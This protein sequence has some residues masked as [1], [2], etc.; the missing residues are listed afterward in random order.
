MQISY[1]TF[2]RVHRRQE[3]GLTSDT[4][5]ARYRVLL[6]AEV[7]IRR[8]HSIDV[9]STADDF[10]RQPHVNIAGDVV[11]FSKSFDVRNERLAEA[12]KSDGRRI[13]LDIC[14]NHFDHPQYGPHFHHMIDLADALVASTPA[15][16]E[17][18]RAKTGRET[19]IIGDPVEG[20]RGTPRCEFDRTPVQ[21][22]WFGHPTNIESLF[23]LASRL[24]AMAELRALRLELVT[25]P[26]AQLQERISEWN[27]LHSDVVALSLTPWSVA[28]L[29]RSFENCDVVLLP[30]QSDERGS[31]KS[32]NR[33]IE[34]IWAGRLA[35]AHPVP[36][37]LEFSDFA[38]IDESIENALG[39]VLANS[40][41]EHARLVAGQEYIATHYLPEHIATHWERVFSGL[42]PASQSRVSSVNLQPVS[43]APMKVA[44]FTL[45]KIEHPCPQ[46]R[47][48]EP[49]LAGTERV[50]LYDGMQLCSEQN[51]LKEVDLVLIQRGFP[52]P[53]LK[54]LCE[55][56]LRSGKPIVYE[57]DDYLQ[58]VPDHHKKPDYNEALGA[59][60]EW[61][62]RRADVV[63]VSTPYL[64][65]LFS[66]FSRR[67]VVLPNCLSDRL[68]T[69]ALLRRPNKPPNILRLGL[70]GSKHH[71]RDFSLVFG[72]IEEALARYD[73]VECVFYGTL[74]EGIRPHQ[75]IKF[76]QG[77]YSYE[78][79][80]ARLAGVNFDIALVPLA[81]NQF[82]RAK[83]NIKFLEFGFLGVS[84]LYADLEPYRDSVVHGE[85]G[86]LCDAKPSSWR[87]A[88]FALIEDPV[89][90]ARIGQRA[91][92]TVLAQHMLSRHAARWTQVWRQAIETHTP[93]APV[94]RRAAHMNPSRAGSH[95][96]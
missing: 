50:E 81:P 22:L 25:T 67:V 2:G 96:S 37:Y 87:E 63:T 80:P 90:R 94:L 4:A 56:L 7:L 15:M 32:P 28:N 89:L 73:H 8:G 29:A 74:P 91:R 17:V 9:H 31:V 57:T 13:V 18:I 86:F 5:S 26:A 83:S 52:R 34:S 41:N 70:A 39:A 27:K 47:V 35:V 62:A 49:V 12:L 38:R 79:H 30:S 51:G 72:L 76:V 14:D 10:W 59:N 16:A 6:P 69:E 24:L 44:L 58:R 85:N 43:R 48:V 92:E 19:A 54:Q 21:L 40:E 3:G 75:R 88:L 78:D 11:V 93:A 65:E 95:A 60:I 33:L 46:I 1:I 64:A 55:A 53:Q 84:G 82:N 71:Q 23:S 36:S 77:D 68:W 45:D 42:A 20:R 61:L 66:T